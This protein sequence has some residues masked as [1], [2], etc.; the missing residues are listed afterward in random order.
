MP[1]C[2]KYGA[3]IVLHAAEASWWNVAHVRHPQTKT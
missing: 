1:I 2:E 3:K